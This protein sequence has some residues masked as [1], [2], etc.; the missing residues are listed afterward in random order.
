[1]STFVMTYRSGG[2]LRM[3]PLIARTLTQA[4]AAAFDVVER[5]GGEVHAFGV[6]R[7]SRVRGR[8]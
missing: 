4:W 3:Q 7:V 5:L 1:M 8:P 2:Q 6:R